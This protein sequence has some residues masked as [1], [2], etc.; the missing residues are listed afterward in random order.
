MTSEN[1]NYEHYMSMVEKAGG[2]L[3]MNKTYMTDKEFNN[4]K[5]KLNL[6]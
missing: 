4:V 3:N 6:V 5:S 2:W 1:P